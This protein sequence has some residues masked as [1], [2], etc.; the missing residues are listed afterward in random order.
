MFLS[1]DDYK[2]DILKENFKIFKKFLST[3]SVIGKLN[4]QVW[5]QNIL[6]KLIRQKC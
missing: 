5:N 1:F 4:R 6:L 2:Q 3:N